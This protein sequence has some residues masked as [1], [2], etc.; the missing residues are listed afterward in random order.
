MTDEEQKQHLKEFRQALIKASTCIRNNRKIRYK[1]E[2]VRE[3]RKYAVLRILINAWPNLT[4][5]VL[6]ILEPYRAHVESNASPRL[7]QELLYMLM[8]DGKVERKQCGK[9][10][11]YKSKAS[12]TIPVYP[13]SLD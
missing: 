13:P 10:Y 4:L 5:S 6:Q 3:I 1:Q 2:G 8:E 12:I 11:R 9:A 7:I